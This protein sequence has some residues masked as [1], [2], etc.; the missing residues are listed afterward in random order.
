M[1]QSLHCVAAHSKSLA[2]RRHSTKDRGPNGG[3]ARKARERDK[4]G[5]ARA[6]LLQSLRAKQGS[7]ADEGAW[8]IGGHGDGDDGAEGDE[9]SS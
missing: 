3:I 6:R 7:C 2:L 5:G 8:T 9:Q 1:R 4:G